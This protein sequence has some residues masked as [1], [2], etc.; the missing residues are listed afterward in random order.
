MQSYYLKVR[1]AFCAVHL[2][3][4]FLSEQIL[5]CRTFIGFFLVLS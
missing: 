1:A 4:C 5:L 3:T 2:F